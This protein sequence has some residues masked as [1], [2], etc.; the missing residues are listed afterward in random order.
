MRVLVTGARGMLGGA[1]ARALA[2]RGDEVTVL[3]R[4]PSGLPVREVRADLGVPAAPL[5]AA[6]AGQ[7]AGVHL[8]AKV[9]VVGPWREYARTNVDGTLRLLAAARTA[10]RAS[11]AFVYASPASVHAS[12]G[13][14]Y[15]SSAFLP[16]TS[17][18][19]SS[20]ACSATAL[21]RA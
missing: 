8:A 16:A 4:G 19:A 5:A 12:P 9:D 13:S 17:A 20:T 18:S 10:G 15:R 7:D 1:V 14:A 2:A 11:P 3:Q 21:L 6:L